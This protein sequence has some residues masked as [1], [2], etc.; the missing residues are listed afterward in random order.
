[1]RCL[2]RQ[3]LAAILSFVLA[4]PMC[5]S[6]YDAVG[7]R[8]QITS[9]LAPVPAGLWNYDANDRFTAG[10]TYDDNG[11]TVISGGIANGYDFENHLIQK[12]GV[13]IVYDGDGNRVQKTVAGVTTKYLVDTQNPTG[14]AQVL[15]ETITGN[16]T[17]PFDSAR[18]YV[19]GLELISKY[20]QFVA[21]NQGQTQI[22]YYVYDGHGSVRAL[23]STTGAVTDT[24]DYDAFGNLIHSTGTT[25]NNYLFAGEQFDPDL[26]LYYNRARY[27][28]VSTGRFWSMD[29]FEGALSDPLSLHKY[30]YCFG[31][32]PD[33]IDRSGHDGDLASAALY[34]GASITI[35]SAAALNYIRV[36]GAV[37]SL[38]V[39]YVSAPYINDAFEKYKDRFVPYEYVVAQGLVQFLYHFRKWQQDPDFNRQGNHNVKFGLPT[40][41][42][43]SPVVTLA[44]VS[45][46][47]PGTSF[48]FSFDVYE[49]G[50]PGRVFQIEYGIGG[51]ATLGRGYFIFRLDYLDF[52]S[53]PHLMDRT[54]DMAM[55]RRVRHQLTST[56]NHCDLEANETKSRKLDQFRQLRH[57]GDPLYAFCW[58]GRN[59]A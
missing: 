27:L 33:C 29:S 35:Q 40:G 8:K 21:N 58:R 48:K 56:M 28:N 26:N 44:S 17:Q 20:R 52:Q 51:N 45:V 43:A 18:T 46:P 36:L 22:S 7:N 11:N 47:I 34:E 53:F 9:T 57:A 41:S 12:A 14:Y 54:L 3:L 38:T 32:G 13:S 31:D 15:F 37:A 55:A 23:T 30:V 6:T 10:D 50:G 4:A 2:F 49:G 25:P 19:Y 24:Y 16:T 1:M 59:S 42:T 39:G 5:A